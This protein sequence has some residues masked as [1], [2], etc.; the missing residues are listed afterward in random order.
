MKK[1]ILILTAAMA[2]SMSVSAAVFYAE[3]FDPI[4][5]TNT[6]KES[7]GKI[8]FGGNDV[9]T[10]SM[11]TGEFAVGT[12][13]DGTGVSVVDDGSGVNNVLFVDGRYDKT[14]GGAVVVDPADFGGTASVARLS[15]DLTEYVRKGGDG[16]ACYV[17]VYAAS[18]YDLTGVTDVKIVMDLRNGA[19]TP[20]TVL[21]VN[22]SATTELLGT[23]TFDHTTALGNLDLSFSY[24]GT[25]AIVIVWES[26][27]K[28][29]FKIDNIQITDDGIIALEGDPTVVFFGG[30][31]GLFNG[32]ALVNNQFVGQT[33]AGNIVQ[34]NGVDSDGGSFGASGSLSDQGVGAVLSNSVNDLVL[35]TL[36]IVPT[37]SN[38][39][40]TGLPNVM[41]IRG[42]DNGKFDAGEAWTFEFN[43]QVELKQLVLTAFQWNSE[44]SKVTVAGVATNSFNPQD[45]N[46]AALDWEGAPA[47]KWVYT[48]PTPIT[49]PAGTDITIE[50]VD[51][52]WGLQGVV[53]D[54]ASIIE[55]L[56]LINFGGNQDLITNATYQ[57][58]LGGDAIIAWW[59]GDDDGRFLGDV[60]TLKDQGAGAT[61]TSVKYG[62]TIE[63]QAI[64][65]TDPAGTNTFVSGGSLG[66]TGGDNAKLDSANAEAWTLD[67]DTDVYLYRIGF[68]GFTFASEEADIIVGGV[69]NSIV[70]GDCVPSAVESG[71]TVYTYSEA[72][73]I[74]AGSAVEIRAAGGQWGVGNLVVGVDAVAARWARPPI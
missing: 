61:L 46:L 69:T 30:D 29:A 66:I 13:P 44:T 68:K 45:P 52:S 65:S 8:R 26:Q 25:S 47:N 67:F 36:D 38:T 27:F 71:L 22:G 7:D 28:S 33:D 63:T 39:F 58:E 21:G 6:V 9:D 43:K 31:A 41:G 23:L 3:D 48:Y 16:T 74:P 54:V 70:P 32:D 57:S 12:I 14:Y 15:F 4:P 20:T 40:S 18:G 72:L 49:V 42:G 24:D 60:G 73:F 50:G 11:S 64:D 62:V 55:T 34:W 51:G 1:C 56:P 2:V 35:T 37:G 10:P 19:N 17:D 53:V 59:G 5:V